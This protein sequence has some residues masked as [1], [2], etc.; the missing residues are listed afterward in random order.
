MRANLENGSRVTAA[1]K[2]TVKII[3]DKVS[4][5]LPDKHYTS[6]RY[7]SQLIIPKG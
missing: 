5:M 1:R 3:V 2:E 4:I 7:Y 6:R